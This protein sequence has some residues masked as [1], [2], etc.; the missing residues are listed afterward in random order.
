MRNAR[1][2]R[3][4]TLIELLVVIAIIAVLIALL[5]PAVQAAREAA[6]R[7]QCVNN[8]K[9]IGLA[10]QNYHD[11]L[12]SY[13]PGNLTITNG[14]WDGPWWGWS[15]FI[16]P[17]I[18][19]S[20][21]YNAI[22][23]GLYA[24]GDTYAALGAVNPANTTVGYSLIKAYTCPS[25]SSDHLFTERYCI[26]PNCLPAYKT[27][28]PSNYV[29]NFGDMRTGTPFDVNSGEVQ[30]GQPGW[31]C[32]DTYRGIFGDCSAGSVK[33]IRDITDRTSNTFLAGENSPNMN[34]ALAWAA[35]NNAYSSTVVPLN[36]FT[37]LK[38]GQIDNDGSV[39][40]KTDWNVSSAAHCYY[41]EFYFYGFKSYHPG[42][43]NF[44]MC[45]GSVKFIKQTISARVYNGLG[46][47]AGG[48]ILSADTY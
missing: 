36:W 47:R 37:K 45:D 9:Q 1:P 35:G 15:A 12:G 11:Q 24:G 20:P 40:N 4:F 13:P 38:E 46:T 19:Q 29:G 18:E 32:K 42:G 28:A 16:L 31:G 10:T 33:G 5:L 34:V 2:R 21:L 41:N 30:T 43:A 22:N 44:A 14:Q 23:F 7:A 25:D 27:A 6:R 39:C 26:D 48:E 8:L 3:G 17:Q